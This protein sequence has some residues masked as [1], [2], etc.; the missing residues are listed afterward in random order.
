MANGQEP[1][2]YTKA[3][4]RIIGKPESQ[5]NPEKV[6]A[7]IDHTGIQTIGCY[8]IYTTQNV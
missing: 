6:Y 5:G 1:D 2:N 4:C 7:V 3:N 8:C